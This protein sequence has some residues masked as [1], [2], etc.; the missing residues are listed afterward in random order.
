MAKVYVTQ[1]PHKRDGDTGALVPSV[2]IMPAAEHGEVIVMMPPRASFF[3]TADLTR[4]LREHLKNYDYAAGDT[5]VALGDPSVMAVACGLL[6]AMFGKFSI[7][8][9]DRNLGRYI[10]AH[11]SV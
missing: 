11:I 9:W 2:N 10:Q 5:L 1:I 3:A 4:Q 6:G 7:L 8:R